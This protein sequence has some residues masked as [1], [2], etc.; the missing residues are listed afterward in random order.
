MS[1]VH[2]SGF[3]RLK[4]K[5]TI[6]EIL[7]VATEFER[8]AYA[9]YAELVPKVSKRIRWLVEE[10][11]EEERQHAELF[12]NLAV[13]PDVQSHIDDEIATPASDHR[14][15]D[16]LHLPELGD[17]PDDQAIL[18]FALGRE[19]AAMDQY[20]ALA[21]TTPE[22]PIRNLFLY[23]ANEETKHKQELEKVYYEVIHSGGV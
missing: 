13:N 5:K 14:F 9:F 17:H 19:Q 11:V 2:G 20:S 16:Q 3:E 10:L 22:G 6:G 15:S 18:Q 7:E 1:E 4:S 23:L 21:E 8:I 12:E